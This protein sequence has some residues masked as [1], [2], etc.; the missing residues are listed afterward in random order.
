MKLK[1]IVYT[2]ILIVF[3]CKTHAQKPFDIGV[4]QDYGFLIKHSVKVGH[5]QTRPIAT[6]LYF[7]KYH[8]GNETWIKKFHHPKTSF[9]LTYFDFQ[10]PVIGKT[11]ALTSNFLFP[12]Y[13]KNK[14]HIELKMGTGVVYSTNPFD[15]Q[16]NFT[17]NVLSNRWSCVMQMGLFYNYAI[18]KHW[19]IKTA[20]QLT[21]YSNGAYKLPNAGVNVMTA[22]I[23]TSYTF[24]PENIIYAPKM[25]ID[26]SKKW[27]LQIA[28]S[29]SL[30]E[31]EVNQPY[32][33]KVI[34]VGIY[35]GRDLS[36]TH[37]LLGGVDISWND[38]IKYQIEKKYTDS[39]SKPD[40]R[41]VS[42][43]IGDEINFGKMSFNIHFGTYL[44]KKFENIA[45]MPVYQRYGL[46]YYWH[47]NIWTG[48]SLKTHLATA[49]SIEL[50]LG[51]NFRLGK[52]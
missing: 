32:K 46:K 37:R 29:G 12:L 17:N 34:N 13:I 36:Q 20:L 51:G 10:N 47:K 15:I 41:R 14:N 40:Y 43:V 1:Y 22:S 50:T 28:L 48:V 23:G 11:V 2:I 30:I 33:H 49:E 19:Q 45:D 25:D 16:N 52:K 26:F 5:L 38:G 35:T 42:I 8:L 9:A 6:T 7:N 24:Y 31:A 39:S 18:D 3:C 4:L 44:Y 21:H 27:Y